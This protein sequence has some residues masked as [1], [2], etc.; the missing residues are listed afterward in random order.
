M[1]RKHKDQ[2]KLDFA[3][4]E[5]PQKPQAQAK[6]G[7]GPTLAEKLASAIGVDPETQKAKKANTFTSETDRLHGVYASHSGTGLPADVAPKKQVGI[8][9]QN[10]IWDSNALGKLCEDTRSK[11]L[12]QKKEVEAL[13]VKTKVSIAEARN[14]GITDADLSILKGN[15]SMIST[16]SRLMPNSGVT[17]V[18]NSISM[19][20]NDEFSSIPEKTAG[21]K[22]SE[23]KTAEAKDHAEKGT[24]GSE[25]ATLT[26]RL[27]SGKALSVKDL[28]SS[29][30]FDNLF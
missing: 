15:G 23:I 3:F 11:T 4:G 2:S 26:T 16:A 6:K 8:E 17:K 24:E 28:N 12:A 14:E 20:G 5:G 18:T 9:N 30:L 7:E 21:E 13:K 22:I 29:S 25:D 10:S 27:A 1:L 19:F